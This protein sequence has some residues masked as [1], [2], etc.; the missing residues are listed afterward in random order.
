[1]SSTA[2]ARQDKV[3]LCRVVE[4]GTERYFTVRAF[5]KYHAK[6]LVPA[7][8]PAR[9]VEVMH[10]VE[11]HDLTSL[12]EAYALSP[13]LVNRDR[14]CPYCDVKPNGKTG[15]RN[16]MLDVH[17]REVGGRVLYALGLLEAMLAELPIN[18]KTTNIRQA[19]ERA[20]EKLDGK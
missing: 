5:S 13:R 9:L 18:S 7:S 10:E 11:S 16:H 15:M 19:L 8:G 12:G 4:N 1:M 20:F 3:F 2:E 17:G 14:K 6:T